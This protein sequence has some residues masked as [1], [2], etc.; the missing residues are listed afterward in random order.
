MQ[1]FSHMTGCKHEF[2]LA[3]SKSANPDQDDS[4]LM[5]VSNWEV[6]LVFARLQQ[7]S[8][9]TPLFRINMPECRLFGSSGFRN[10]GTWLNDHSAQPEG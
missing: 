9:T 7:K 1:P 4:V 8:V 10:V 2:L 3:P 6:G 5:L